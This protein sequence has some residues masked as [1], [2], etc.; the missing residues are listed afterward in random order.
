MDQHLFRLLER[1]QA[2]LDEAIAGIQ[3]DGKKVAGIVLLF[4]GGNDSTTLAHMFRQ[5]ATHA[6][7]ANTG[8]GIEQTRQYVRD[9]CASWGL[10]LIEEHPREGE[11]YADLV[12]GRCVARTGPNAGKVVWGKGFPGPASHWLMY[13]RL[14]ERAL[15]RVRNQLVANPRRERVIFLAGRRA[16]ESARRRKRLGEE[17]GMDP[18]ERKGS[19]VWVSPL[20]HWSKLD[21]NA[22]RKEFPDCPR[23]EV[24]DLLH[25]SG[26]CLCGAF[27]K[28]G[29]LEE[30]AWWFPEAAA[31]IRKLEAT[32]EELGLEHCKWGWG[33]GKERA[34]RSG[35]LCSSCEYRQLTFEEVLGGEFALSLPGVTLDAVYDD[36]AP[37]EDERDRRERGHCQPLHEGLAL[38]GTE[39]FV[40]HRGQ[41]C[42]ADR[43]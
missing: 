42:Q 35:P 7:H 14:K 6:A 1:S 40:H 26:E 33:A 34:S 22:Y 9:T 5:Q 23:N 41:Q 30:I 16:E 31:E 12:L 4:S 18:V 17:R 32:A 37:D 38:V 2:I 25:M 43:R 11:T 20:T 39:P 15:E 24:A 21:L 8:I 19:I 27:A 13:T 36:R 29:E 28:A 3:A 10:P